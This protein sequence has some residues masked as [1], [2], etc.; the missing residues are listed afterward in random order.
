MSSGRR[1]SVRERLRRGSRAPLTVVIPTVAALGAGAALA[2]ASI[3]GPG[4]TITG[5]YVTNT[6]P[7]PFEGQP[8]GSLRIIDPSDTTNMTQGASACVAGEATITWNQ[9]GPTGPLGPTGPPGSPGTPG[10]PGTQG[11]TGA[12][13]ASGTIVGETTFDIEAARGT[14]ILLEI[15]GVPTGE[16]QLKSAPRGAAELR[17]FAIGG[18]SPSSMRSASSGLGA[19]KA[20]IETFEF[21]KAAGDKVSQL[22]LRDEATGTAI[23]SAVVVVE[24]VKGSAITQVAKYVLTHLVIKNVTDRGDAETVTGLF[25][26]VSITIGSGSNQVPAG[27]NR[28]TNVPLPQTGNSPTGPS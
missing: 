27:W 20:T 23:S 10:T 3:P 8:I 16:P 25:L 19:G 21:V 7:D 1:R 17:T 18:E 26:K 4:G 6:L 14:R 2:V 13:G 24:H 12:N 28:I 11:A 15:A 9:Q 22:L 5:C